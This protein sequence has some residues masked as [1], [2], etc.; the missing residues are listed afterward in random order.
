M[1][2]KANRSKNK[3][4]IEVTHGKTMMLKRSVK[5]MEKMLRPRRG[6]IPHHLGSLT[7]YGSVELGLPFK[8][9]SLLD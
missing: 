6:S 5:N 4:R 9:F 8:L 3:E 2:K 7:N 1:K